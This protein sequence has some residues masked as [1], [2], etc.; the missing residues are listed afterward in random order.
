ME[1]IC[2]WLKMVEAHS[3]DVPG[4]VEIAVPV[5]VAPRADLHAIKGLSTDT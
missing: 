1:V 2:L 3:H 5:G 4:C